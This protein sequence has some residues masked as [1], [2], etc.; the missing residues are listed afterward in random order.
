MLIHDLSTSNES[1][2]PHHNDK[3]RS[4]ATIVWP[5]V[6]IHNGDRVVP[7]LL[8]AQQIYKRFGYL[9]LLEDV[10]LTLSSHQVTV[11]FGPN[12]VGKTTLIKILAT[13]ESSTSGE[14]LYRGKTVKDQ[15]PK[16][17][18]AIGLVVHEPLAY[19]DLTAKENLRFLG[20]IYGLRDLSTRI[21]YLLAEVG[22][23]TNSNQPIR[24][25]SRGMMQKFM[26]AKALLNNPEILM[27]DEPFSGLDQ[28]AVNSLL[29]RIEALKI[30][31]KGI[32][33]TTHNV[34]L[35]YS[36]GSTFYGLVNKKVVSLGEKSTHQMEEIAEVYQQ[37]IST[38]N[39]NSLVH[40][41]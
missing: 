38:A 9:D 33:M 24:L 13:L 37:Q 4:T 31:G 17:R 15:L 20:E 25:F 32:L 27:L 16:F 8:S 1:T 30:D 5:R 18:R 36:A 28:V 21:N 34:G 2:Q 7:V 6:K 22:L 35:G 12:G 14:L 3:R 29:G 40:A 39:S 26:I 11:I 10:N 19:P 41:E 23:A